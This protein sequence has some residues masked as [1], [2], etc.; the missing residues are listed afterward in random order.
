MNK[1]TPEMSR[2]YLD[3]YV[4]GTLDAANSGLLE[5]YLAANPDDALRIRRD[6]AVWERLREMFAPVLFEPIPA[7]LREVLASARSGKPRT[8]KP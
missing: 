3:D 6:W 7:R 8:G 5:E 4:S 1:Q 2:Q